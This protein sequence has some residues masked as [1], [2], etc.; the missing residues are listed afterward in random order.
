MKKKQKS[1][2]ITIK[3]LWWVIGA[4]LVTVVVIIFYRSPKYSLEQQ[5]GNSNS[6]SGLIVYQGN[7]YEI[8]YPKNWQLDESKQ[9]APAVII[10]SPDK[11]VKVYIHPQYDQRLTSDSGKTALIKNLMDAYDQNRDYSITSDESVEINGNQAFLIEGTFKEEGKQ[12]EFSEYTFFGESGDFYT[13]RI[14][15]EQGEDI[16]AITNIIQSFKSTGPNADEIKARNL[17]EKVAEVIAFKKQVDIGDRSVFTVR[18]DRSPTIE[19]PYY[20][21]QVYEIFPDHTTTFNW[22]RVSPKTW[23]VERQDLATDTWNAVK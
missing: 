9:E 7:G 16:K 14:N 8:S 22:Y 15:F 4:V 3:P 17:V 12:L 19:I 23:V 2:Q 11:R 13:V 18:I 20:V 10:V 1:K 6:G 5:I 21:V